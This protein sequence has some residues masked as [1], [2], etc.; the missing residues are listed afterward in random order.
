[1]FLHLYLNLRCEAI[2]GDKI[3]KDNK[4]NFKKVAKWPKDKYDFGHNLR[5]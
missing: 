2:W 1:M 3:I 5:L 4:L